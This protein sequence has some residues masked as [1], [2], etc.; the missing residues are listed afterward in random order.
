MTKKIIFLLVLSFSIELAYSQPSGF[1][2]LAKVK[3]TSPK[4]QEMAG[5]CW[6]FATTSFIETEALRI[7]GT[8]F[9]LSENYF[10]YYAYVNKAIMYVRKQGLHQFNQGGQAHDVL[11]IIKD[12]GMVP[13]KD[14]PYILKNHDM[15]VSVLTA[16]VDSIVKLKVP[17]TNWLDGYKSIL[18]KNLGTPPQKITYNGKEYTPIDFAYEVVQFDPDNYIEIGSFKDHEYY[19]NF[20]LEVPDNWSLGIYYNVPMDELLKISNLALI[21]GYSVDWDG[22]VSE[23]GFL[24][25]QGMALIIDETWQSLDDYHQ[26]LYDKEMTT[27][28]HLMHAVGVYKN[29][30]GVYYYLIKNS[31]GAYGPYKGF[32]YMSE[33][34]YALKSIAILVNKE[35]LPSN[36]KL[37]LNIY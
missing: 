23:K 36:I 11:D 17:P 1:T 3:T 13:D 34:F 6:D 28:D 25:K 24:S 22:D 26:F 35:I 29:D 16:Y 4:N 15:L 8:E 37:M 33:D 7:T 9:D 30:K 10:V 32:L 21:N 5:T 20:V 19:T 27:D 18:N 31:W 2:E 12:Y 14:Y